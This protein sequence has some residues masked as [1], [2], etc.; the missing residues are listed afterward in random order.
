[1]GCSKASW[2]IRGPR[3]SA[4]DSGERTVLRLWVHTPTHLGVSSEGLIIPASSVCP[5]RDSEPGCAAVGLFAPALLYRLRGCWG[6]CLNRDTQCPS[7]LVTLSWLPSVRGRDHFPSVHVL[8]FQGCPL[9][10]RVL[11]G[12]VGL[13]PSPAPKS[14][15]SLVSLAAC[16]HATAAA[17][18]AAHLTL[19][20]FGL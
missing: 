6:L 20:H 2:G 11:L 10:T 14:L 18:S 5:L 15:L 17:C 7:L 12:L 9:L 19:R 8:L 4:E 16:H 1:M 3:A 13:F